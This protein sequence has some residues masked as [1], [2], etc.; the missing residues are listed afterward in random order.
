M[1]IAAVAALV[2]WVYL[3][4]GHGR[5]WWARASLPEGRE[6]DEWPDVVA[7]VPARDEAGILPETLPTLLGQEYPGR[8]R[9][10]LVD[11]G[12]GDGTAQVAAG[13][14]ADVVR[15]GA[16]PEGW[17]G[18]VW[19]MAEGCGRRASLISCCSPMPISLMRPERSAGS[20]GRR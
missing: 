8:F 7:V 15:A 20:S 2:A 11:D 3:V 13:F 19:A 17:A 1:G 5:F 6:P 9:V 18:K 10:V 4:V 12:S 16:R 14:G